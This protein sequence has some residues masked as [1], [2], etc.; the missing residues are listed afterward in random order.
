MSNGQ[1]TITMTL[2]QAD[3]V[4][5]ILTIIPPVDKMGDAFSKAEREAAKTEKELNKVAESIKK[6]NATPTEKLATGMNRARAALDAGKISATDFTREMDRLNKE[7]REA[8]NAGNSAFGGNMLS[9]VASYA[10]GVFSVSMAIGAVTS[11]YSDFRSMQRDSVTFSKS[12]DEITA[13]IESVSDNEKDR[14]SMLQKMRDYSTNPKYKVTPEQA[15]GLVF[16]AKSNESPGDD[17]LAAL[18]ASVVIDPTLSM[19]I[20]QVARENYPKEFGGANGGRKALD[21]ALAMGKS[22]PITNADIGKFVPAAIS[23]GEGAGFTYEEILASVGQLVK[24]LG[25]TNTATAVERFKQLTGVIVKSPDD[26]YDDKG[27]ELR[28]M[29]AIDYLLEDKDRAKD[30]IKDRTEALDA[31]RS[32][33]ILRHAVDKQKEEII[34]AGENSGSPESY[35]AERQRIFTSRPINTAKSQLQAAENAKQFKREEKYAGDEA[36]YQSMQARLAEIYTASGTDTLPY[37]PSRALTYA[38]MSVYGYSDASKIAITEGEMLL[39]DTK[40]YSTNQFSPGGQVITDTEKKNIFDIEK[41]L[42]SMREAKATMDAQADRESLDR[43]TKAVEENTKALQSTG[44]GPNPANF[45]RTGTIGNRRDS[46]ER[47]AARR[48]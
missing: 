32:I 38:G 40:R 6:I 30:I 11:A 36:T 14:D 44:I 47:A 43:N 29:K 7:F 4:R 16:K 39:E 22:S 21:M 2:E 9:T 23:M 8:G 48:E 31:A 3:V 10:A 15:G 5:K 17:V 18:E 28:G 45:D 35:I 33:G 12:L 34:A 27:N 24:K 1:F 37:L 42:G 46:E 13:D 20:M 19:D 25:Q 26:F 41:S